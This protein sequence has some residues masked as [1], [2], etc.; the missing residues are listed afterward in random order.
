M[1][2]IEIKEI[3]KKLGLS[4]EALAH[5]LGVSFQTINRWES[6]AFKPSRLAL[7]KIKQLEEKEKTNERN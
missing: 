7:E 5:V 6:G 3:R 1:N 2:S 4:Q